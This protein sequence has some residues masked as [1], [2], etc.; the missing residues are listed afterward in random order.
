MLG[1]SPGYGIHLEGA[2]TRFH[3][4]REGWAGEGLWR[5]ENSLPK[6]GIFGGG[7]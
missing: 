3:G 2:L 6:V 5:E 1:V 7:P 4:E